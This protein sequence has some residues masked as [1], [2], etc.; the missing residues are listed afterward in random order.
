[1]SSASQHHTRKCMLISVHVTFTLGV[2]AFVWNFPWIK[3]TIFFFFF[4]QNLTTEDSLLQE[5]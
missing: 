4:A 3:H 2:I 5:A 1:M